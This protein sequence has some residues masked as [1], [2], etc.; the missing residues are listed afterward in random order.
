MTLNKRTLKRMENLKEICDFDI[1]NE[2]ATLKLDCDT[3]FDIIDPNISTIEYPVINKE[4]IQILEDYLDVVPKEFKVNFQITIKD[5]K[6]YKPDTILHA[7]HSAL[8]TKTYRQKTFKKALNSRMTRFLLMG[9]ILAIPF[10]FN[11]KYNFFRSYGTVVSTLIAFFLEFIFE[12]FFEEGFV[13][14][15]VTRCFRKLRQ[16]NRQRIGNIQL[17]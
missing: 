4:A 10:I 9:L 1:K 16:N 6:E 3:V 7:Y 12:L 14:F 5:Y 8:N 2:I 15:V 17:I 13:Y 11:E